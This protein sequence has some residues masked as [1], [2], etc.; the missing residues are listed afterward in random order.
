[1]KLT[2]CCA[3]MLVSFPSCCS[4]LLSYISS[5]VFE[6]VFFFFKLRSIF[7][8]DGDSDNNDGYSFY[9]CPRCEWNKQ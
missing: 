2:N 8:D 3:L 4:F 1:M 5:R 7:Y 6:V 9:E